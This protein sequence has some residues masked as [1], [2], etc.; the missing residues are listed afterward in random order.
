MVDLTALIIFILSLAGLLFLLY[1]KSP[2]LSALPQTADQ[3]FDWKG[4]FRGAKERLPLKDFRKEMFLQKILSRVRILSLKTESKT[5][6]WLK[7]LRMKA[8][9]KRNLDGNYWEKIKKS[10]KE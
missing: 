2:A 4:L 1:K 6:K 8:K 10:T 9:M 7:E 5:Q 3:S